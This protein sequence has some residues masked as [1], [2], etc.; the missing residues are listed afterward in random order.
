VEHATGIEAIKKGGGVSA[1][2][3]VKALPVRLG[4][5]EWERVV[6]REDEVMERVWHII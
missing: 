4:R 2:M 5:E 1:A 6:R 3:T